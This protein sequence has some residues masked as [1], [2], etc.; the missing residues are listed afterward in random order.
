[1]DLHIK[2]QV[3]IVTGAGRHVGLDIA[4]GL[5]N[6]G[7]RVAINDL[8]AERAEAAAD[9]I[10]VQDIDAAVRRRVGAGRT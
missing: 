2:G 10:R 9:E 5:A 7:V 1:M 3:A 6:E 8:L 4:K